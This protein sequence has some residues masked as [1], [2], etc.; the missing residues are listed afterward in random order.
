MYR[1]DRNFVENYFKSEL[2]TQLEHTEIKEHETFESTFLTILNKHAPCKKK[3]V[4]ANQRKI[5][6]RN[7]ALEGK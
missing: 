4:R 6:T 1:D 2:K 3:I 7:S 5:S